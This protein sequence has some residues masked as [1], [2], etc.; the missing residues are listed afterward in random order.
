[1]YKHVKGVY[2][3]DDLSVSKTVRLYPETLEVIEG[4]RGK[5]FTEKLRNLVKD[6]VRQNQENVR[7]KEGEK[8][9]GD[10]NRTRF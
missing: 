4:Y 6:F 8:G 7:Q 5:N 10:M 9:C 3:N 1:M 2:T